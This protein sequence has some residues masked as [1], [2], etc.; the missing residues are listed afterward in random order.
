MNTKF[1]ITCKVEEGD[2]IY[3]VIKKLTKIAEEVKKCGL[4]TKIK[5]ELDS[6][7]YFGTEIK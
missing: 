6:R 4:D 7:I 1:E 2:T 3:T 5:S